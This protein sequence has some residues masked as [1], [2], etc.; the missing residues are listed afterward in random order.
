MPFDPEAPP[1][2][3]YMDALGHWRCIRIL[4]HVG[5]HD[6]GV[7][8]MKDLLA[9]VSG[10][11][12]VTGDQTK[13]LARPEVPDLPVHSA[14]AL[15]DK[16]PPRLLTPQEIRRIGAMQVEDERVSGITDFLDQQ[17]LVYE[18]CSKQQLMNALLDRDKTLAL[19]GRQLADG[20]I[21]GRLLREFVRGVLSMADHAA[22]R[23]VGDGTKAGTIEKLLLAMGA[24]PADL[25]QI[26]QDGTTL[27][28]TERE[29]RDAERTEKW[30]KETGQ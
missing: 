2:C 29:D 11:Q 18:D 17:R 24:E 25:R 13:A 3:T 16:E 20:R 8:A 28:N 12:T 21:Q 1:Q 30:K 23:S 19:E 9:E 14:P 6:Q 10:D 15:P 7:E 27:G 26:K 22:L 5:E 4:G